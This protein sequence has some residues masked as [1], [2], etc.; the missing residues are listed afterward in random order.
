MM[1]TIVLCALHFKLI[2]ISPVEGKSNFRLEVDTEPH[3]PHDSRQWMSL[4]SLGN[5]TKQPIIVNFVST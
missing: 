5:F 4:S 3:F 1:L 2:N